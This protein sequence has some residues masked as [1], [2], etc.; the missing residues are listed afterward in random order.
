MPE[1]LM[2][3]E[4]AL[5]R[6]LA[7]CAVLDAEDKPLLEAL[8]QVLAENVSATFNVP[9]LDN[10]GMDG[11]AVQMES[12]RGAREDQPSLLRLVGE[13]AAG[14]LPQ[15]AVGPG[16]AIRIMTGA[17]IPPGAD[18]VVPFEDTDE[19]ER[20]AGGTARREMT[21]I[22]IMREP[23]IGDNVRRAGGDVR[24]GALILRAGTRLRAAEIGVLATLGRATVRVI[25]RPVV[26][27]LATG[28]EL[29]EPG[30]PLA[31]GK[32]YNSNAYTIAGLVLQAGGVPLRLGIARDTIADLREKIAAGLTADLFL[33]SAGVS[34][35]EY[36]LVKDVLGQQGEMDFWR[37][38]M[39]PGKPLAFGLL[40]GHDAAGREREVPHL[41]LPGNPV[42]TMVAFDQFARPA[43]LK[44][45]GRTS[46][47][48]PTIG[49][50]LEETV[51]NDDGRRFYARAVVTKRDGRY[52][53]RLTGPQGSNMLTSMAQ[54]NA[55]V[56]V[57]E[58]VPQVAAGETVRAQILDGNEDLLG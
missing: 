24:A 31:P 1:D 47:T 14:Y 58:Y 23:R 15:G 29:L 10:S 32:I 44:L 21:H 22:G 52:F 26:A 50:V 38:R 35:G 20:R 49:A 56:I 42:S 19:L 54:A 16:T 18:T 53:A 11:Y 7:R 12:V 17:P 13:I 25:R 9:P 51:R 40:R 30:D 3:V 6:I 28:D 4:E 34:T 57:P 45:Q 37:V 8:G 5:D 41:G 39:R 36:D 46:W 27:I 2:S 33:T 43:L 48:R 55:L